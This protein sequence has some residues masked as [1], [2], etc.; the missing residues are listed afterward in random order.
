MFK[1]SVWRKS[2]QT[3][4]MV[5]FALAML[6]PVIITFTNALMTE[7]E[8]AMNYG[9]IGK[10]TPV[11]SEGQGGEFVYLEWIPDW[12]SLE[13][14]AHVLVQ[15]PIFLI[16][17]W[18]S[19]FMVIP[20]IAG[21][22]LVASLAAYALAKLIFRGR[23]TLFLVYLVTMLMPFQVTLVPNYIVADRLGLL[24]NMSA[25]IFPAIFAAFGVFLLRQFMLHIPYAFIEAAKMDGASHLII[26]IKIIIPLV[27]P[28]V[29]ALVILLFADYW[30]MIEQPL[31][32]LDDPS[33]HP[34]SL[35]LSQIIEGASGVGFA[36]SMLYMTPM[37]LLFLYAESYFI[38]GIQLT[39]IKG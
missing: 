26:F 19:V 22:M 6:L 4:P 31:I 32:L 21:Q 24:N 7:R 20:I 36:A 23:D 5:F 18:N 12:V 34:L 39:G 38:E 16:K 25:I 2:I 13:Q 10:I 30:N 8:I 1:F 14:Y 27:K 35:Y 15:T 17:F 9:L 28:G 37:I 33:K 3:I 11:A 29:A